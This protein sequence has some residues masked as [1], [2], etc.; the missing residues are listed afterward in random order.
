MLTGKNEKLNFYDYGVTVKDNKFQ[1]FNSHAVIP[2]NQS[3]G[4]AVALGVIGL[5]KNIVLAGFDGYPRGHLMQEEMQSTIRIIKKKY[6]KVDLSSVT[7][8]NYKI[9][10][11]SDGKIEK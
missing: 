11:F 3:F 9:N 7:A 6:P 4:Y 10:M 1:C 2:Y 8:T 5:A